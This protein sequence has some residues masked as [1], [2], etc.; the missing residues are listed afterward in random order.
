MKQRLLVA[1]ALLIT[2]NLL[3]SAA[4]A[5]Q[6]PAGDFEQLPTGIDLPKFLHQLQQKTGAIEKRLRKTTQRSLKKMARQEKKLYKT[7]LRHNPEAAQAIFTVPLDSFSNKQSTL[8]NTA[9]AQTFHPWADSVATTLSFLQAQASVNSKVQSVCKKLPVAKQQ[10]GQL[11]NRLSAATGLQ[12]FITDRQHLLQ[13]NI[14][15]LPDAKR[16]LKKYI[17]Q[18]NGY[19]AKVAA[20]KQMLSNRKKLEAAT[21]NALGKIPAFKKFIAK[22]SYLGNLLQTTNGNNGSYGQTNSYINTLLANNSPMAQQQIRANVQAAQQ[23]LESLKV[24]MGG[25][26]SVGDDLPAARPNEMRHKRFVERLALGTQYQFL[27]AKGAAPQML[28][29]GAQVAY[30]FTENSQAGLGIGY[31]LGLGRSIRQIAFS[32][33]GIVLRSFFQAKLRGSIHA[34]AG[35]EYQ[36]NSRFYNLRQLQA[37]SNQ[38]Q[39]LALAGLAKK[40]NLGSRYRASVSVLYNFLAHTQPGSNPWAV[41]YGIERR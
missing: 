39:R 29:I 8:A 18:A 30:R 1:M 28:D 40:V 36:F 12:S 17:Q 35:W 37:A 41:R 6:V 13:Q 25:R 2:C 11:D 19:K 20:Y 7:M 21:F 23:Q 3:H 24:R 22:H 27:A 31:R 4:H 5:Q 15:H 34:Q 16:L 10:L 9:K 38:W 33:E 26:Q 14:A 32:H